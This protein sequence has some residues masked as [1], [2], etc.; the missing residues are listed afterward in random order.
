[1]PLLLDTS[2]AVDLIGAAPGAMKRARD[3]DGLYLSVISH[4]ELE[5]G[6]YRDRE[7][8]ALFRTRLERFLTRV[9]EL[10][11]TAREVSA[12]GSI[13]AAKGFTRRLVVDRMIAAT[14]LANGLALATLNP[15]DFRD[16]PG[17][18]IEDWAE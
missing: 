13:I 10:E 3:T 14:A 11:F 1:L 2:V 17:L 16:I 8:G 12:Y 4:V 7:L 6:V 5:A 9:E 15:R 18:T